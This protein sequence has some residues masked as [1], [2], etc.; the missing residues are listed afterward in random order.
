MLKAEGWES[1][2]L[3]PDLCHSPREHQ[4]HILPMEGGMF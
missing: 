1:Q 3:G 2:V 4:V